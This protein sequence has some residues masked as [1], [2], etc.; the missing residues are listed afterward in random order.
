MGCSIR[1]PKT[2]FIGASIAQSTPEAFSMELEFEIFNS[3]DQ[4]LE[5]MTCVYI[6]STNGLTVYN[7]LASAEQTIPRWSSIKNTI[8]VVFR[9]DEIVGLGEVSWS[10]S[11]TLGY[12]PPKAFSEAL[13]N[14][15]IWKPTTP[16]RAHGLVQVPA[17]D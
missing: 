3:N 9:R 15:G 2:Q 8:P 1:Q 14:S 17:V 6:V 11:G 5:L 12:I 4:P 7:G 10:L 13:L 16:I